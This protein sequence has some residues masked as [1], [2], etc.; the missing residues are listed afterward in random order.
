MNE[1]T[2]GRGGGAPRTGG[3]PHEAV[4]TVPGRAG[5]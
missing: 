5:K 1:T 3:V 4:L 2:A